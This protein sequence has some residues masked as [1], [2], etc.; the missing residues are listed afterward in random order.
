MPQPIGDAEELE[1]F[2]DIEF[3]GTSNDGQVYWIIPLFPLLPKKG[4]VKCVCCIV[5]CSSKV[6]G[7]GHVSNDALLSEH[8]PRGICLL[9]EQSEFANP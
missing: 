9:H 8:Q 5:L 6:D 7:G 2:T 3:P 4:D 1:A